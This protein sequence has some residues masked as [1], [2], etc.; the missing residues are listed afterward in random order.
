MNE[1]VSKIKQ[2]VSVID[3]NLSC[4]FIDLREYNART[5]YIR[6]PKHT[7]QWHTYRGMTADVHQVGQKGPGLLSMV[8]NNASVR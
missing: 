8:L 5:S 7:Q 2:R 3:L 1:R 6:E 4:V